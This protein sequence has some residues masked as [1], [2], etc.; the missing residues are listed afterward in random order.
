[1]KYRAK[2]YGSRSYITHTY[3]VD[4]AGQPIEETTMRKLAKM[5]AYL[6]HRHAVDLYVSEDGGETFKKAD[7]KKQLEFSHMMNDEFRLDEMH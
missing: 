2:S 1:M 6:Y 4:I 5:I 3:G 7:E